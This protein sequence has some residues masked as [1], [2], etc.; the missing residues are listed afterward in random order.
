MLGQSKS[1]FQMSDVLRD[2]K[3]LLINLKGVSKDTASLAGTLIMN[4][5]WH[6][7]LN[8]T[9]DRPTYL[10]LDEFAR[11]MD[12]PIDTETM[13]AE[14]RKY[15]FG[16]WLAHQHMTQ[17]KPSVRDGVISNGRNKI[18]FASNSE[19]ATALSRELRGE[20]DVEDITRLQA[21]EAIASVMVGSGT[22]GPISIV[23][24]PPGHGTGMARRV[25][26]VS[27]SKYGRPVHKV[28]IDLE[29]RY[30]EAGGKAR[31]IR[32]TIS[33]ND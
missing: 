3:I 28:Q 10:L 24:Q 13:L 14:A 15:N 16:M 6:A 9:T 25:K 12:L 5:I 17:L 23:T 27:R 8:T 30:R 31:R 11:F 26:A 19:D 22:S 32:P 7:V 4:A 18:I 29:S 20:V 21:F 1:A 33:G 2:N